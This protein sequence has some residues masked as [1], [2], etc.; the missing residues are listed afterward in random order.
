MSSK[1]TKKLRKNTK[2]GTMSDALWN[3]L[4]NQSAKGSDATIIDDDFV[5]ELEETVEDVSEE[6]KKAAE[7][8]PEGELNES[9][10][11]LLED[12]EKRK[13]GLLK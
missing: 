2:G 13:R 12:Y 5:A 9:E 1:E 10:E 11:E 3:K 4:Q 7:N 6:F 8:A